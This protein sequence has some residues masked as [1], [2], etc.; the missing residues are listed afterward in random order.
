MHS[1]LR[2]LYWG[3]DVWCPR[4]FSLK[5]TISFLVLLNLSI[6]LSL[7][8]TLQDVY[9]LLLL[10]AVMVWILITLVLLHISFPM[11]FVRRASRL[12]S[13]RLSALA[14]I[15]WTTHLWM[16]D[17]T[18]S[19]HSSR[20]RSLSWVAASLNVCPSV[21][22]KTVLQSCWS[23]ICPHFNSFSWQRYRFYQLGVSRQEKHGNGGRALVGV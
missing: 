15:Y 8:T 19:V 6:S 22:L 20:L 23:F 17:I 14:L 10:Q 5:S 1:L 13:T 18:V 4:P 21:H 2:C 12:N 9:Q 11:L 3:G 7:C 16:W